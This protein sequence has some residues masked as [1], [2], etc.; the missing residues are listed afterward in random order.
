VEADKTSKNSKLVK[1]LE[2][3]LRPLSEGMRLSFP[4]VQMEARAEIEKKLEGAFG[5]N[6]SRQ[7][8]WSLMRELDTLQRANEQAL[9]A[10]AVSRIR[11]Q[12]GLYEGQMNFD[13]A[14][15]QPSELKPL[16]ASRYDGPP[17]DPDFLAPEVQKRHLVNMLIQ[18][19]SHHSQLA[20][21]QDDRTLDAIVPSIT[22][23]SKQLIALTDEMLLRMPAPPRPVP[24]PPP[25]GLNWV[26]V[27][28]SPDGDESKRTITV[29][30]RAIHFPVLVHELAKGVTEALA[31]WGLPSEKN[32][33][34]KVYADADVPRYE[35]GDLKYAH[36][37]WTKVREAF[38]AGL[39]ASTRSLMLIELFKLPAQHFNE[40]VESACTGNPQPLRVFLAATSQKYTA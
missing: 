36:V 2:N 23:K 35:F 34:E 28:E 24:L 30:A 3:G 32:V 5:E 19:N 9:I 33:R 16:T 26:Q 4:D 13:V 18:G 15:V 6:H 10:L 25:V 38:P 11:E 7:D 40:L 8:P 39:N 37:Y 31:L 12:F 27:S 14:F 17:I 1:S 29:F 21:L 22:E 20:F